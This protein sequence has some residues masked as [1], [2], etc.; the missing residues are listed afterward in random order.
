M[1]CQINFSKALRGQVLE[2][3]ASKRHLEQELQTTKPM[4]DQSKKTQR[5]LEAKIDDLNNDLNSLLV[6]LEHEGFKRTTAENKL[7]VW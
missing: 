4:A 5:A 1:K 3:L 6:R 2:L 7:Q